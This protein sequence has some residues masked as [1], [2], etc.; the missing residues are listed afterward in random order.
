[1][2]RQSGSFVV[3]LK[4]RGYEASLEKRKIYFVLPDEAAG[5]Q[6]LLRVIGES[7]DDYLY[8]REF[9]SALDLPPAIRRSVMAAA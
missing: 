6:G 4:N 1:M 2:P 3:C 9:F 8:P 7:G 5:K